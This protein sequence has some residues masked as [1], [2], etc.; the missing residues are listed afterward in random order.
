MNSGDTSDMTNKIN[1]NVMA[2]RVPITATT[3][4]IN[5]IVMGN[6]AHMMAMI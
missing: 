3:H 4:I 6:R 1:M 2:N 5:T